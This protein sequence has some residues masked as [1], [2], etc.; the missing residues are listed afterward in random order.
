MLELTKLE[1]LGHDNPDPGGR[2][3]FVSGV[4]PEGHSR[5]GH[6]RRVWTLSGKIA[7]GHFYNFL[8]EGTL[9]DT[10]LPLFPCM[11]THTQYTHTLTH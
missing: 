7:K 10:L 2:V 4:I 8:R 6:W 9:K 3:W 11:H 5:T 1:V